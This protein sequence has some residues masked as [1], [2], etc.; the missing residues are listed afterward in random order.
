MT[1]GG[2]LLSETMCERVLWVTEPHGCQ[3]PTLFIITQFCSNDFCYSLHRSA[4]LKLWQAAASVI[5]TI[6]IF[7][8]YSTLAVDGGWREGGWGA[9]D[10]IKASTLPSK[11]NTI[12]L[13][14][15]TEPPNPAFKCHYFTADKPTN[16][17]REYVRARLYVGFSHKDLIRQFAA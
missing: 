3:D 2:L 6:F 17:P 4:I 10:F 15:Y 14:R 8:Y 7:A 5:A 12:L 11:G 13:V 9:A 16:A 1:L